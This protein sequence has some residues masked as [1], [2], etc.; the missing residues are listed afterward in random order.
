MVVADDCNILPGCAIQC[1]ESDWKQRTHLSTGDRQQVAAPVATVSSPIQ[2]PVRVSSSKA[3]G[4][5]PSP[6][7][8]PFSQPASRLPL[9]PPKLPSAR[10]STTNSTYATNISRGS[11]VQ[12]VNRLTT[13]RMASNGKSDGK[14]AG[15]LTG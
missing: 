15:Q 13:P 7:P 11:T 12:Y 8:M 14:L 9:P 2:A 5:M 10:S 1:H 4:L 6:L 3:S